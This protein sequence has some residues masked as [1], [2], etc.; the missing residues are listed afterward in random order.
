[1]DIGGARRPKR[2]RRAAHLRPAGAPGLQVHLLRRM[3]VFARRLG[4]DDVPHHGLQL[5]ERRR[6]G[7]VDGR[8]VRAARDG[9]PREAREQP[10]TDG[11]GRDGG[12]HRE[13]NGQ[14]Q[15]PH[16]DVVAE[17]EQGENPAH[18]RTLLDHLVLAIE[19]HA[20]L[21]QQCTHKV[22]HVHAAHGK[23]DEVADVFTEQFLLFD[24][25]VDLRHLPLEV[26]FCQDRSTMNKGIGQHLPR[27]AG[28][29]ADP[30]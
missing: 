27:Q 24:T 14:N 2:R 12:V 23:L 29:D 3:L 9:E 4:A 5:P 26:L 7:H 10:H 25:Q 22:V 13:P 21:Q 11:V 17:E 19:G 8:Q 28:D 30:G 1:M 20:E 6:H 18:V 15:I 16:R